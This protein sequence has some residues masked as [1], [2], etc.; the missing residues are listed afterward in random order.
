MP[1]FD[2]SAFEEWKRKVESLLPEYVKCPDC[3]G[4]GE[5]VCPHCGND[6]DCETCGGGG[7]IRPSAVITPEFYKRVVVFEQVKLEHWLKGEPISVSGKGRFVESHN[8]FNEVF[9][10]FQPSPLVSLSSAPRLILRLP[11]TES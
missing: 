11:I 8:P 7:R 1:T 2:R 9:Q 10:E 4:T 5:G 3:D 6:T